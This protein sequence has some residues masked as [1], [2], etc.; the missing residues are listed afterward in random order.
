MLL[1]D[2]GIKARSLLAWQIPLV[3]DDAFMSAR[4]HSS[5]HDSAEQASIV[6]QNAGM[7][8]FHARTAKNSGTQKR[9]DVPNCILNTAAV[10]PHPRRNA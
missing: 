6:S 5:A 4:I 3:T 8:G 7:P 10:L 1:K 2:N 9:A